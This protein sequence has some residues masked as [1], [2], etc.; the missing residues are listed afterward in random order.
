VRIF[1]ASRVPATVIHLSKSDRHATQRPAIEAGARPAPIIPDG[2]ARLP[3][4]PRTAG[5]EIADSRERTQHF[6]LFFAF[7]ACHGWH[8]FRAPSDLRRAP[9][10]VGL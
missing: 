7:C 9:P 3:R 10:R 2:G 1:H 6:F 8:V 4:R 5:S